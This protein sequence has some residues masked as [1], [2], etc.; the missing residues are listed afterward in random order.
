MTNKEFADFKEYVEGYFQSAEEKGDLVTLEC[1]VPAVAG[2][3]MGSKECTFTGA[4][5]AE[6]LELA[7]AMEYRANHLRYKRNAP[8]SGNSKQAQ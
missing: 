6:I 3:F 8:G 1:A 7:R 5:V 2:M 4:Q